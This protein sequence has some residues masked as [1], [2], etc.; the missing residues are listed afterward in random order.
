MSSQGTGR[1]N[2]LSNWRDCR[3]ILSGKG[4]GMVKQPSTRS[5]PPVARA[6]LFLLGI[7]IGVVGFFMS[8]GIGYFSLPIM[9]FGAGIATIG[10]AGRFR[11]SLLIGLSAIVVLVFFGEDWFDRL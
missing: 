4:T 5:I 6:L 7:A 9:F 2:E 1:G 10:L 3:I 11:L 8:L